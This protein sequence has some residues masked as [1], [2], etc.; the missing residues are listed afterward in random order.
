MLALSIVAASSVSLAGPVLAQPG[1]PER[2]IQI[3]V[4]LDHVPGDLPVPAFETTRGPGGSPTAS[5]LFPGDDS[6][7]SLPVAA[8]DL[9]ADPSGALPVFSFFGGDAPIAFH[10]VDHCERGGGMVGIGGSTLPEAVPVKMRTAPGVPPIDFEIPAATGAPSGPR[11]M[12]FTA[13]RIECPDGP[14]ALSLPP[15]EGKGTLERRAERAHLSR[16]R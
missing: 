1:A 3:D 16:H 10:V 13:F 7:T 11:E 14:P 2:S 15:V 5:A 12:E 4:A 6:A 8:L 9:D